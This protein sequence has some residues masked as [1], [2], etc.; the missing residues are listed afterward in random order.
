MK[1][2][3]TIL[4]SLSLTPTLHAEEKLACSLF[5]AFLYKD[6]VEKLENDKQ[7]HCAMSCLIARKCKTS[8]VVAIGFIKEFIDALGYG[9]PDPNDIAANLK[10]ISHAKNGAS[11]PACYQRCKKDYPKQ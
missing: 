2:I 11:R 1:T 3:L 10:G 6:A 4:I 8:E 9:T 5:H 7:M